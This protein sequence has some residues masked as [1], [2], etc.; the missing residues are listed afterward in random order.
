[1]WRK[2][3]SNS[4]MNDS[5]LVTFKVMFSC[6]DIYIYIYTIYIYTYIYMYIYSFL[7]ACVWC[8]VWRIPQGFFDCFSLARLKLRVPA[9]VSRS[10][11][12][13]T[14]WAFFG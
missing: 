11:S 13:L 14:D 4:V 7:V 1:M 6:F 5:H 12:A 3:T 10:A 8:K 2:R 9:Q